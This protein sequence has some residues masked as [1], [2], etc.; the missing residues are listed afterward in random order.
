MAAYVQVTR[1][2][3]QEEL[4]NTLLYTFKARKL[5]R[6]QETLRKRADPDY[7][8]SEGTCLLLA[9]KE[10]KREKYIEALL[11]SH[12]DPNLEKPI[13][14][15]SETK[16]YNA[17]KL[18]VQDR[19][20]DVNVTFPDQ[21]TVLHVLC[22]EECTPEHKGD[23]LECISLLL[24]NPKIDVNKLD[25]G[26]YTPIMLAVENYNEEQLEEMLEP[27]SHQL[28]LDLK[29]MASDQSTR[30]LIA[31]RFPKLLHKLPEELREDMDSPD[32]Q[33]RLLAALQYDNLQLF[34]G[35]IK[36]SYSGQNTI[37]VNHFYEDPYYFTC[38]EMACREGKSVGFIKALYSAG[39]NLTDCKRN[40]S[41][42]LVHFVVNSCCPE[43]LEF[44]LTD[45]KIDIKAKDYCEHTV[46]HIAAE[47]RLSNHDETIRLQKCVQLILTKLASTSSYFIIDAQ[48]KCGDTALQDA[49]LYGND[50]MTLALLRHGANLMVKNKNGK[51]PL[52]FITYKILKLFLDEHLESNSYSPQDE[53]YILIFNYSFLEP[54]NFNDNTN[55]MEMFKI[56]TKSNKE[57]LTHP[58]LQSFIDLKWKL[59]QPYFI[60]NT[61]GY[62]IFVLLLNFFVLYLSPHEGSE[63]QINS[64]QT[65]VTEQRTKQSNDMYLEKLYIALLVLC[66]FSLFGKELIK[67]SIF[68]SR[69]WKRVE[70][71]LDLF[72]V[73]FVFSAL[74]TINY[75]AHTS[76]S[77]ILILLSWWKL[78]LLTGSFPF[79][80]IQLQMLKQVIQNF[81]KY[82]PWY[83]L[84][85]ILPF[86]LCFHILFSCKSGQVHTFFNNYWESIFK[87][88]GMLAGEF[89]LSNLD[90]TNF[91]VLAH[92]VIMLFVIV[93]PVILLNLLNGLAVSDTQQ[94]K[95]QAKVLSIVSMINLLYDLEEQ[96]HTLKKITGISIIISR[97]SQIHL[98]P[99]NY[100][101]KIKVYC[102]SSN[103]VNTKFFINSGQNSFRTLN[104]NKNII[105][106][107][108]NSF[109]KL[110]MSK[111]IIAEA[112]N[113]MISK[114]DLLLGDT[115]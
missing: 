54:P 110:N 35:L 10:Q 46:L 21:R 114:R 112:T 61:I 17:I 37:D 29:L 48:D 47:R 91:P 30:E 1:A 67:M 53:Q 52:N 68:K 13:L 64:T 78:T 14:H 90:F 111:S 27:R 105:N 33:K 63:M 16:N 62:I 57:I 83:F 6:F 89:E 113:L 4:Q 42:P 97:I 2:T 43:V 108:Q 92:I 95:N 93:I 104:M 20:T 74:L 24:D 94:I 87:T 84:F 12:A 58:V 79:L 65:N 70:N 109:R 102:N 28:N 36:C 18:L 7:K 56:I 115:I 85:L 9:C 25:S 11:Q 86:A 66:F 76:I 99:K 75:T 32:D 71:Y 69:Y 41:V 88:I 60:I 39:A 103:P 31:C 55:E 5:Q 106:S 38:M 59:L 72:I 100:Q 96:L 44:L 45:D 101:R 77:I 40:H 19:R 26:A 49:V 80:S 82:M 73:L 51:C 50:M 23:V 3:T 22:M 107:G 8:Y 34:E 98:I 81:L 15:A